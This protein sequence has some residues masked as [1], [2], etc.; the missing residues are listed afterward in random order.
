MNVVPCRIS[1]LTNVNMLR[2]PMYI[3]WINYLG[4]YIVV[5]HTLQFN[6]FSFFSNNSKSALYNEIPAITVAG[7]EVDTTVLND[8]TA[9]LC[10]TAAT[11]STWVFIIR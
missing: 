5:S 3:I 2:L 6:H 7:S 1:P 9:S 10:Y 11:Y 4:Y 8:V